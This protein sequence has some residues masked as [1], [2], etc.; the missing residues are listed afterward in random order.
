MDYNLRYW[1]IIIAEQIKTLLFCFYFSPLN[2]SEMIEEEFQAS[3]LICES[4]D[5]SIPWFIFLAYVYHFHLGII[6]LVCTQNFQKNNICVHQ[7]ND[8][9]R[10]L[11]CLT[12]EDTI[13][14][15]QVMSMDFLPVYGICVRTMPGNNFWTV[16]FIDFTALSLMFPLY[17]KSTE[18]FL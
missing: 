12:L 3:V 15:H 8:P 2:F 13:I 16:L 7:M 11:H 9:L 5:L 18:Y 1:F 14:I 10:N 17:G 6:H 4:Y